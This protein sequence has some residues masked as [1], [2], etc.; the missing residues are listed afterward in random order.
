MELKFKIPKNKMV[1]AHKIGILG[2]I[3]FKS[4]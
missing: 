4:S 1:W 2:R 3:K